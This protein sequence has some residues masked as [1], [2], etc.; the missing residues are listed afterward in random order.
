MIYSEE[1]ARA[2]SFSTAEIEREIKRSG[3]DPTDFWRDNTGSGERPAADR[4]WSG[5]DV[6]NWLGY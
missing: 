3:A 5:A 4:K 2:N 6:L 1:W